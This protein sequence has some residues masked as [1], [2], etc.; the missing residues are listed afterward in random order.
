MIFTEKKLGKIKIHLDTKQY[1]FCLHLNM[2]TEQYIKNGMLTALISFVLGTVIF[3]AYY[4]TSSEMFIWLGYLFVILAGLYNLIIISKIVIL[5][6]KDVSNRRKL[7]KT[8][9]VMLLNVPVA[10]A[11]IMGSLFL[12]ET[13]RITFTNP[14]QTVLT[15]IHITG[16]ETAY[17][18]KL[19]A[20]ESKTVWIDITGDCTIDMDYLSGD[21][22][23]VEMVV[24][25]V[26]SLMGQKIT[27]VIG[28][29]TDGNYIQP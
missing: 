7:L 16:C 6:I 22:R 10:A 28:K 19:K 5:A 14:S 20:A 8:I 13:M 25:Y 1:L 26:T 3:V 24:G 17:I 9:G 18:D 21:Q 15:D 12:L 29:E 23:K 4:F 2:T 27:H 11:Y